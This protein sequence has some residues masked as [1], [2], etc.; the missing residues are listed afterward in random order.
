MRG[1]IVRWIA[2]RGKGY[3]KSDNG[4][5]TV[6]FALVAFPFFAMLFLIVE[7]GIMMFTEYSLQA[8]VTKAARLIRTGQAQTA[9]MNAATFKSAVCAAASI[10]ANCAD[11]TVYVNSA[12]TFSALQASLPS[13]LAV[14]PSTNGTPST[15]TYSCGG[16]LSVTAVVATYDWTILMP[17]LNF[18]GNFNGNT[19]FRMAGFAMFEN[20]PYPASSGACS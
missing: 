7:T 4:A 20:E 14:G 18:M 6:E 13:F 19:K 5:A 11:V 2:K 10:G 1:S 3:R 9:T 8:G 15:P 12:S 17:F 16:P